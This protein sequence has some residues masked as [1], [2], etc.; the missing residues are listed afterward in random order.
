LTATENQEVQLSKK[1][2]GTIRKLWY[3]ISYSHCI[4]I[5]VCPRG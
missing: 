2:L 5:T 3:T 1:D 4:E